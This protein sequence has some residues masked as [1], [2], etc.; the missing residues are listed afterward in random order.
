MARGLLTIVPALWMVAIAIVA[1]QNATP[2]AVQFLWGRS[3]PLPFGVV[4]GFAVAIAWG[5]T[6]AVV[7]LLPA[8]PPRRR[9]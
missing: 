4:L 9:G 8:A 6:G 2:V 3:V 5:V 7:A 1:V